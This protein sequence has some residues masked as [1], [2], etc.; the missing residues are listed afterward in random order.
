MT[1]SAQASPR[2]AGREHRAQVADDL[3]PRRD[4]VRAVED[5]RDL[6][7]LRR[8]DL[9][10]ARRR[11]SAWPRSPRLR[12]RARARRRAG[13]IETASSAGVRSRASAQ[14]RDRED[15]HRDEA[16][17]AEHQRALEVERAVAASRRAA[18]VVELALNTITTPKASRQSVAVSSSEYSTGG[19]AASRARFGGPSLA[20][21]SRSSQPL[22]DRAEVLAALLEVA[23][24]VEARAGRGEQDDLAPARPRRPRRGPRARD[25][26]SGAARP[27][28]RGRREV[29]AQALGRLADQVAGG[30]A[31]RR[32]AAR[33]PRTTRP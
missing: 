23:V 4:Q 14:A 28:R 33:A 29:V 31:S 15:P 10:Q 21:P 1:I 27:R 16:E 8:L 13:T 24:G 2:R 25:R 17:R 26:R 19:G 32:P 11:S 12:R 30:A 5:Q 9:E 20:S 7:E 22:D 3:R 18:T 6:R